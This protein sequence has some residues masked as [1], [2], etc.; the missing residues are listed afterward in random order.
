MTL[1]C[2]AYCKCWS[3]SHKSVFSPAWLSLCKV[4]Y[5][6]HCVQ[7]IWSRSWYKNMIQVFHISER[8]EQHSNDNIQINIIKNTVYPDITEYEN[9][10]SPQNESTLFFNPLFLWTYCLIFNESFCV[11]KRLS[12]LYT[13][14]NFTQFM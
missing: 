9:Q 7:L 2:F 6:F 13:T 3:S 11:L 10:Y 4:Q 1:H 12:A 14:W 8:K 5:V